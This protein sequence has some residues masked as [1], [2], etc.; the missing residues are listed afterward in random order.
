MLNTDHSHQ[1]DIS[2]TAFD[3]IFL[4]Y[5]ANMDR[6]SEMSI[7]TGR[8]RQF[9]SNF[10]LR[11]F[12]DSAAAVFYDDPREY[13]YTTLGDMAKPIQAMQYVYARQRPTSCPSLR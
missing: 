11:Q 13:R 2:Y 4:S 5:H 1:A 6:I 3:P 12:V 9:S 10:P 7:R 8:A